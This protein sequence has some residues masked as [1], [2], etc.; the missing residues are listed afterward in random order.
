MDLDAITVLVADDDP[1]QLAYLSGLVRRLRPDWHI[2][3]ELTSSSDVE[4]ELVN[5]SPSLAIL[6]VRFAD[7]T[8]LEIVGGLHDTCPVIFV[9]GDPLFAADAFT[10]EALDF[11]LKPI[12]TDRFEH[13]LRKAESFLMSKRFAGSPRPRV[14]DSLR[15][16]RGHE[17]VWAQLAEVRYFEAQ[18]KYTRVV[19]KDQEGL[20]KMGLSTVVQH[21]SLDR[22]WRIHRGLI[23][24]VA[25]MSSAKRDELGRLRIKLADRDERLIVSKPY[26]HLFRDGFS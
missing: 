3:A 18:R 22:F 8:S 2:V 4:K 25:H 1:A 12:K 9:T 26:E 24:N 5:L 17:L 23:L 10:A 21:V 14:A 6:D 11:I 16:F 13:A 7:T 19:L 20:L 15:M